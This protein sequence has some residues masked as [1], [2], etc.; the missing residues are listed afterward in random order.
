MN[1]GMSQALERS[2]FQEE[3]IAKLKRYEFLIE[4]L[5]QRGVLH[6][7]PDGTWV[8][9]GIYGVDDSGPRGTGKSVEEALDDAIQAKTE[10]NKKWLGTTNEDAERERLIEQN[11]SMAL[12]VDSLISG[13][14]G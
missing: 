11:R 8:L 6:E 14:Q 9:K 10:I 5:R 4:L 2:R 13:T 1:T 7:Y 12:Y 3:Q